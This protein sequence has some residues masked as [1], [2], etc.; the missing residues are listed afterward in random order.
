MIDN[1]IN[2]KKL[3]IKCVNN[4]YFLNTNGKDFS[5]NLKKEYIPEFALVQK[6]NLIIEKF[7]NNK[8]VIFLF[9]FIHILLQL[10]LHMA[11]V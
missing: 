4:E 5:I 3:K 8:N 6:I 2:M 9:P 11:Q 7:N 10:W 1:N